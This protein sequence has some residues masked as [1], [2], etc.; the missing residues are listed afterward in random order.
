M[1]VQTALATLLTR[2]GAGTDIPIGSP[3]A[4]RTDNALDNLVGF[5]INTLVLRTDTSGNPTFTELLGRVRETDLAAYTHQDVPF[6]RLVELLNPT[7]SLAHNP[8]FQVV[9]GL[10]SASDGEF[11]MRGLSAESAGVDTGVAKV[12]LAVNLLEVFGEGGEAVGMR[13]VVEFATDL[14]D[15]RTAES[16]ALR[17]ERLLRTAV[18]DASRPI[19]ELDILS[20]EE[21]ELLLHGWNDTARD[22]PDAT[23][24][25]LFEAQVARTPDAPA[26]EHEGTRLTYTEL[27][28]RANQFAHQLIA[29]GAGPEKYV[30]VALPRS[31]DFVVAI[32]AI[33]KA[34]AAYVPLDPDYPA[35]RLTYMLDD[36]R[37]TLLV[38]DKNTAAGLPDTD[39]TTVILDTDTDTEH[40]H[41]DRRQRQRQR[42]QP[43]RPPQP[44][45]LPPHHTPAHHPPRLP[46]LHLR[47][48]RAAQ[49]RRRLPRRSGQPV[50]ASDG[51][52]GCGAGVP[53]LPAGLS[54]LRR[55]RG[56]AVHGPVVR[57]LSGTAPSPPRRGGA[58]G[59][60]GRAA[61]HARAPAGV[62]PGGHAP[63][64]A[65]LAGVADGGGRGVPAGCHGVLVGGTAHGQRLW[66]DRGHGGHLLR[67]LRP[68]AGDGP[69][70]D[71][72][73]GVRTPGCTSST[74]RSSRCRRAC[75]GSSISPVRGWPA[76]TSAVRS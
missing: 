35:D 24:P 25:E 22:V 43:S 6:E 30:A 49:G 57:G 56:G 4:G 19:A 45:Q 46:H 39:L 38:T 32:L 1:V 41:R 55:V 36:A 59:V 50:G 65:A 53:G 9:L 71:R 68:R 72:P 34:G 47:L 29:Q 73:A 2:L 75:P 51:P 13:G 76:A 52:A 48:H 54:E 15:R 67:G 63:S 18:D 3:I 5:F 31:I 23:L 37:P 42:H 16:I 7:R 28:T 33:V 58:R 74:P 64:G 60:P 27:N 14:F 66:S 69:D 62:A 26:L 10:E 11:A 70:A 17:L 44:G 20:V 8:L 21:R 40:R 61:D 12:D